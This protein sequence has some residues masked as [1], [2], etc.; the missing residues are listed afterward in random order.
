[1]TY[2]LCDGV[3]TAE[4]DTGLTLLDERTG[5]YFNLNPTGA[6][7]LDALLSGGTTD[8]AVERLMSTYR[9]DRATAQTDVGDLVGALESA[10]L[11]V[12]R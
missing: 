4:T 12:S 1:M 2:D 3:S 7:V 8:H 5:E 9:I 6:L 11:V 10:G